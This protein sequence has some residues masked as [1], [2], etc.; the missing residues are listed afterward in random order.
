MVWHETRE[1]QMAEAEAATGWTARGVAAVALAALACLMAFFFLYADRNAAAGAEGLW[2]FVTEVLL[3]HAAG[4]FVAGWLLAGL[5]GRRGVP[6][7]GLALLGAVLA[8]LLAGLVGGII[9][10]LPA[11]MSGT[12]MVSAAIRAGAGALVTP[13]AIAGAPWLGAVWLAGIAGLHLTARAL[14]QSA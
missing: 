7:W 1:A 5:F 9:A 14:R 4:G 8:S 11:L 3:G 13:L 10:T 2:A 6:G 12:S